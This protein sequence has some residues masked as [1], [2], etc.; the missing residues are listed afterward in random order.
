MIKNTLKNKGKSLKLT[1]LGF[2]L[3]ELLAVIVILAIIALIATP[4]VLS[5]I[6]DTKKSSMLRSAEMYLNGVENSV[7]KE[8][9]NEGG[10]YRPN[11]CT[12]TNGLV[13]CDDY[14]GIAVEVDGEVPQDGSTIKFENGKI[15]EVRLVYK[16]ATIVMD[17]KN[18]LVFADDAGDTGGTTENTLAT[19]CT[20]DTTN[21]IAEKTAGAK[22]K[23]KVKE[24]M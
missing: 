16:S 15:V 19:I 7:M 20:H 4:I 22:Y 18:N 9:M 23:C 8:N 21:G 2:T 5:I 13:K 1:T 14:E 12:I 11:D 17:E 6:D 24:Q 3:I 10:N